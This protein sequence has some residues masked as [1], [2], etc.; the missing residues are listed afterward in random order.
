MTAAKQMSHAL[1]EALC[2][3]QAQRIHAHCRAGV[4]AHANRSRA[5]ATGFDAVNFALLSALA[6]KTCD[7]LTLGSYWRGSLKSRRG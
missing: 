3:L 2:N 6:A 7:Y 5:S 4:G 1:T